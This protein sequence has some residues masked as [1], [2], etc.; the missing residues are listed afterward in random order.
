MCLQLVWASKTSLRGASKTRVTTTSVSDGVVKVVTCLF[1]AGI[2]PPFLSVELC[3]IE[4]ES[5]VALIPELAEIAGPL[6]NFLERRRL[7]PA[8]APLRITTTGDEARPLEHP[9]VLR[10]CRTAHGER[11]GEFLHRSLPRCQLGQD[12][13]TGGVGE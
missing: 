10:N 1:V 6:G 11:L 2:L 9:Q 3:E 5:L 8:G 13:A 7:E 12:G 4:V